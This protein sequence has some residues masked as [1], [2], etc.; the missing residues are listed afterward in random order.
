MSQ[1]IESFI[2]QIVRQVVTDKVTHQISS[3]PIRRSLVV[4]NWKMNMTL[5]TIVSFIQNFNVKNGQGEVVLC[6]PDPYL[7]PVRSLLKESN[8]SCSVGAQNVHWQD[9][10]AYTGDVSAEQL[11][12]I[13]CK[14]IIIG[15]SERRMSGETNDMVNKKV[16]QALKYNL[17]PIVCVGESKEERDNQRTSDVV[18]DQ[19]LAAFSGIKN[20][21]QIVIAYEPI[22]AIGTGESA[23]PEQAQ[24]VHEL[25]RSTL[26]EQYG[27]IATQIPILYGG[28]VKPSNVNKL[29]S[30]KD[31][32]GVLV[33][34]ASL[35]A[36][37]F[38]TITRAFM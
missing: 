3:N 11:S 31:I 2:E 5:K 19:V 27:D 18:R 38:S 28:S 16:D 29:S 20:L 1:T 22:W 36:D 7:Y 25:I 12:D 17:I 14:Y 32:D 10:G 13:G 24:G 9:M 21:S 37:D 4:A 6:P 15:H 33:G 23:S 35:N 8:L 34:G 30:M 26:F